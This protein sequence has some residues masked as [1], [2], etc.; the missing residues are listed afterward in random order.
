MFICETCG[1]SFLSQAKLW[2]HS[3]CHG[4]EALLCD[5]C[6]VMVTGKLALK[7]HMRKHKNKKIPLKNNKK[8]WKCS[9]CSYLTTRQINYER[10]KETCGKQKLKVTHECSVCKKVFKKGFLFK[11]YK[12]SLS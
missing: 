7:N 12:D 4:D 11:T 8:E 2:E 10:Q 6:S 9:M 3:R 1:R 5:V